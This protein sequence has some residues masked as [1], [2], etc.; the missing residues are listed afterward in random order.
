MNDLIIIFKGAL[1]F[2]VVW[3]TEL[4]V[5]SLTALS[6]VPL[7]VTIFCEEIKT[8]LAVVVS[9]AILILTLI[10]IVKENKKEK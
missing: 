5:G 2:C 1:M 3:F 7:K 4:L 6:F 8:P 9:F 10:R